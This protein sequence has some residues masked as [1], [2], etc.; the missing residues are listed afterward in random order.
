MDSAAAGAHR[1]SGRT[2]AMYSSQRGHAV[3][4]HLARD[5]E[6]L[7]RDGHL[8]DVGVGVRGRGRRAEQP[9]RFEHGVHQRRVHPQQQRG[10]SRGVGTAG[11]GVRAPDVL[12]DGPDPPGGP[13]R[14]GPVA[15]GDGRDVGRRGGQ[16]ADRVAP[17]VAV[18]V[19]AGHGQRVQRLDQHRPQPRDRGGQVGGQPPG[20][21]GR[22]EEPVVFWPVRHPGHQGGGVPLDQA[23]RGGGAGFGGDDPARLAACGGGPVPPEPAAA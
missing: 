11:H 4:D 5:P 13:A 20:H 6:Q 1:S 8:G 19:D 22:P 18:L 12:V 16:P 10:I 14:A 17:P 23:D 3:R 7:G 2:P 15:V 9:G 21:A